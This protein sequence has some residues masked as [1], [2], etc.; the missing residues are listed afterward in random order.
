MAEI[1]TWIAKHTKIVDRL[2]NT[3]REEPITVIDT[4]TKTDEYNGAWITTYTGKKFHFLDPQPEE[5]DIVDIAHH[6]SL[7]CR[8]TGAVREFYSV[9]EHCIRIAQELKGGK[10]ALAGLL[11]DA[12]EAYINDI[13]RPVKYSH[14]LQDTEATITRA[15]DAKFGIDSSAPEVKY[16]DNKMLATEARDLMVN[17]FDWAKL[18]E[19]FPYRIVP[20]D[21]KSVELQFL[22]AFSLLGGIP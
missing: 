11:H 20:M 12:S 16:L 18:P 19:P 13:S 4:R 22:C 5:I 8:Y 14:K 17:V 15:I 7:L 9:G 3:P 21:S 1:D 6:L 10:L 2:V